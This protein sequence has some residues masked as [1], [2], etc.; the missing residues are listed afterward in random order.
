MRAAPELSQIG[1]SGDDEHLFK[2]EI[3]QRSKPQERISA[4]IS[5]LE[6]DASTPNFLAITVALKISCSHV[7]DG[8]SKD[9]RS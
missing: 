5:G 4:A 8:V 3:L 7:Q 1:E 6:A 2:C 9:A